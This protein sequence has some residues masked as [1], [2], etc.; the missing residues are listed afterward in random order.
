MREALERIREWNNAEAD[1]L[2]AALAFRHIRDLGVTWTMTAGYFA[3]FGRHPTCR[4]GNGAKA[5]HEICDLADQLGLDIF[6]DTRPEKLIKYYEKFGFKYEGE[7]RW[8][9]H[10]M[11]RKARK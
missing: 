6:L 1:E 7:D 3:S 9:D 2:F 8:G 11:T 5:L 10:R 4:K